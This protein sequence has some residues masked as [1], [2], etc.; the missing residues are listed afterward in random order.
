MKKF[1]QKL[2]EQKLQHFQTTR[3]NHAIFFKL[4]D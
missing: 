1:I 2:F 3:V 4:T